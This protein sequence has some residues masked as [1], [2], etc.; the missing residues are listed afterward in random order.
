MASKSCPRRELALLPIL[1]LSLSLMACQRT[2]VLRDPAGQV[3]EYVWDTGCGA[4]CDAS[5]PTGGYRES[6][7]TEGSE[8]QR[9]AML[10]EIRPS[11]THLVEYLGAQRK[12]ERVAGRLYNLAL[13]SALIG[14]H[15]TA[16]HLLD[17]AASFDA[18]VP[19]RAPG[20][21]G[22]APKRAL[23][24]LALGSLQP[25]DLK[26][27][28]PQCPGQFVIEGQQVEDTPWL[29]LERA[30]TLVIKRSTL[31]SKGRLVQ[32]EGGTL[33]LIDATLESG[34]TNPV[35]QLL[36]NAG[37]SLMF[38]HRSTLVGKLEVFGSV[39]S[40]SDTNLDGHLALGS[41]LLMHGGTWSNASMESIGAYLG[42]T[43]VTVKP[44]ATSFT[45][46]TIEKS[47]FAWLRDSHIQG[48]KSASI[49]LDGA[50]GAR[51]VGGTLGPITGPQDRVEVRGTKRL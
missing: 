4:A 44:K 34:G 5:F 1:A 18:T 10:D 33:V 23:D 32:V 42:M 49:S 47:S 7:W 28:P 8:Q 19:G 17:M 51:V 45:P 16:A 14:D 29:K 27:G 38:A 48:G 40:L 11:M 21:A 26:N 2:V 39:A 31:R 25:V 50:S 9:E 6:G 46:L 3:R 30:C 36:S 35:V 24:E 37:G 12:G 15:F 20:L 41:M 22:S 43:N 13:L